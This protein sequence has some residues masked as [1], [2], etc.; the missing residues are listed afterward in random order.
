VVVM[1]VIAGG[2]ISLSFFGEGMVVRGNEKGA[3]CRQ[4]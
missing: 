4:C 3:Y 1:D 2:G